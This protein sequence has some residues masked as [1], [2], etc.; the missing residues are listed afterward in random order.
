MQYSLGR[1]VLHQPPD[2]FVPAERQRHQIDVLP[3][4]EEAALHV[5][6]LPRLHKDPFDRMLIC[7]AVVHQFVLVT[8]DP[9][10]RQYP[11]VRTEW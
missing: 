1:I 4:S 7:Q 10:I 5:P 8:P 11:L 2:Q 6:K 9:G 3:L